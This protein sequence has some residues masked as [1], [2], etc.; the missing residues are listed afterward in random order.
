[1][2]NPWE[3]PNAHSMTKHARFRRKGK[4]IISAVLQQ[5]ISKSFFGWERPRVAPL[6]QH[7]RNDANAARAP[8]TLF[9]AVPP[10]EHAVG[11]PCGGEDGGGEAFLFFSPS[12]S[13]FFFPAGSVDG[14]TDE[15]PGRPAPTRR[16]SI[17]YGHV[18]IRLLLIRI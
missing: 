6:G 4:Q 13:L 9:P 18:R 17:R 1:M 11:S 14:Y 7:G 15:P 5:I 3:L 16:C 2:I 10:S 8:P 12:V